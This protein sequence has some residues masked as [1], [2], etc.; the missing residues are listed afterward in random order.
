[1]KKF[2]I[3]A[4]A[5]VF[6]LM[7]GYY[8]YYHEG[9]YLR[10]GE[11]GEV[12]SFMST[13]ADTIYMTRDGERAPFEIRGVN[14]GMSIP[15]EWATDYAIDGDTYTRWFEQIQAM[16]A[17]T[18]RVYT[19]LQDDFYDAFYAY[20]SA[21]EA[22]GEEPLWLLQG[23]WVNDYMVYSHRDAF[24][25]EILDTFLEDCRTMVDVIHGNRSLELGRGLGS[26]SYREDV[27]PWVIGYILGTDWEPGFIV[28]TN[29]QNA[30]ASWQGTYLTTTDDATPFEAM[31]AQVGDETIAYESQ[32]YGSQRL[33]AFANSVSTDP[34]VYPV[35]VAEYCDK[36]AC[37]NVE[38]IQA[39]D[40]F[41]AGQFASYHAYSY[42]PN[43]L[44]VMEEAAQYSLDELHE[45]FDITDY[46]VAAHRLSEI[47]APHI[48]DWLPQD[49]FAES[50]GDDDSQVADT[51]APYL[52]VLNRYH[53]MPVVIAEYGIPTGRGISQLGTDGEVDNGHFSESEQGDYLIDCYDDIMAA[54]SAGSCLSSWQDE[55]H[56]RT[57]N[58]LYAIDRDRSVYW[59]DYQTSGQFFG[60]LA[61]DPGEEESVC[62]VDGQP[63]EWSA[64]DI[65]HE[66]EELTLS[67]KYDEKFIYLYAQGEDLDVAATPLYI[68]IDLTPNS[69][70]TRCEDPALDFERACDF[71]I[72][73]D[74]ED[75]S[76]V[77]VQERYEALMSTYGME[78]YLRDA[79]VNTPEADS[80]TF[81]PIYLAVT[82]QDVV[83]SEDK[84]TPSGEKAETG[85]LHYGNADPAA[86]DYDSLAD[87]CFND[88]GVEIRIPWQLLNF[89]DPSQMLI[90]DDY[91]S[92][93]GVENL[94]IEALYIGLATDSAQPIA[95]SEVQLEGW[96]NDVTWHE[97]L[98]PAYS[99]LKAHWTEEGGS[100]AQ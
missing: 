60:L 94:Q 21:R 83:P 66:T 30:G 79:Y 98:K 84:R 17:N 34:F 56:K 65:V 45:R 27:S 89:S 19:I 86:E 81:K 5:V 47:D 64:A 29:E 38:H 42:T 26:G 72:V 40:A 3:A 68:P 23:V 67:L 39:T 75:D 91:Y 74:G 48:E 61:F 49:L 85:A 12:T 73:I 28:Y 99:A 25:E 9:L 50:E 70:S 59:S 88:D 63:D 41:L 51:Y 7:A 52:E 13:D 2:I 87:F 22:A 11:S 78:Y 97:R 33:L 77:L 100:H 15:G 18:I 90:H 82:L 14:L 71:L 95:L 92:C 96:G 36:Y 6:L 80:P 54:G 69:G 58:T 1:M 16:G 93:Y 62:S 35:A 37:L 53:E 24:D 44:R 57:W 8:A 46:E 32:R 4:T 20:N 31:L 43:Y 10:L 55:W 76:R